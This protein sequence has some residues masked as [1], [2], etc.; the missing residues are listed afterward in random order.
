MAVQFAEKVYSLAKEIAEDCQGLEAPFCV[1]ECP[2][3]TDALGYIRHIREG[4]LEEAVRS[5]REKLFLPGTLGRI[6]AHPCE[7]ACRRETEFK[8]PLAI[9]ALKRYAADKA[10]REE[11]WDVSVG[12]DTGK[13]VAVV[14]SGPA[15]AQAAIDL[16][17]A[18]H[19]VTIYDRL[20]V[21]GGMLRVGIPAYRLPHKVLD[22]EYSYLDRL[23]ISFQLG[24]EV[25]KSV[26]LDTLRAQ[27]DAVIL[28]HG[29]HLG[30]VPPVNGGGSGGVTN[31]VEF[32]REI[33]FTEK[34]AVMGTNVLVIGGGDVAMDCARSALR[35]GAEKARIVCLENECALP[36]SRHE[37][38]AAIAEGVQ[39]D[40]GWCVEEIV[41]ENGRP[42]SVRLKD[43]LS[44]WDETG[45]FNPVLGSE[46]SMATCD[47]IIYAIG[48]RVDDISRGQL[49]QKAGGR[50]VVDPDTLATDLGGVFVAGDAAGS[51]IAVEA[52][53]L[54]RKAALSADRYL[55]GQ[56][57]TEGRNFKLERSY[58]TEYDVPVPEG[59][60]DLAR[61]HS[62]LVDAAVRRT[63][64]LECDRGFD[65][66]A[67][68]KEASRCLEC[69]CK[70]C[71]QECLM[72]NEFTACPGELFS[73]FL[74]KEQVDAIVPYSCNLCNQCTLVCPKE[75]KLADAFMSMR[76]DFVRANK[77]KS[78]LKGHG[79]IDIHQKLSFSRVFTI[80]RKGRE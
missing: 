44:L 9:A 5:I 28:A 56:S 13:R 65:E 74:A 29:A 48:Q 62:E 7:K 2:M 8:Q 1:A 17:K 79:A 76:K 16:R 37:Q 50:Y 11:L 68:N 63:N 69:E 19:K 55:R 43:C 4:K 59:T 60:E 30:I 24:V 73:I 31:A 53:A 32:L 71:M 45:K 22:F 20:P 61:H 47:T 26:T 49:P 75:F 38:E 41:R 33:A 35:A 12:A 58:K 67:A 72:L 6:C 27:Y 39:F 54:G 46:T 78:P 64:F 57:L 52:M 36:A 3:H 70:E 77:G 15:G 14:G 66:N 21:R 51:T 42:V 25:G 80:K 10:D 34:C 18:G 23:G 40:Y